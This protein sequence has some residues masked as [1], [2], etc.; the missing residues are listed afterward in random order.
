M[1]Y[2]FCFQLRE[3]GWARVS[4]ECVRVYMYEHIHMNV[5]VCVCV[6]LCVCVHVCV[7]V[8]VYGTVACA[9]GS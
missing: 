3:L 2:I 1:Y 5:Y 7:H 6:C 9:C 4:V 8:C